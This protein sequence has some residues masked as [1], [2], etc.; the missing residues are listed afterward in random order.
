MNTLGQGNQE[1][2]YLLCCQ[3]ERFF[4]LMGCQ[5]FLETKIVKRSIHGP[6]RSA[7]VLL[8]IKPD[9]TY[10][11]TIKI[12]RQ[13]KHIP[14]VYGDKC[15]W[16][17]SDQMPK[18]K[19]RDKKRQ[20]AAS[21]SHSRDLWVEWMQLLPTYSLNKQQDQHTFLEDEAMSTAN[22]GPTNHN[23]TGSPLLFSRN[24]MLN[25]HILFSELLYL[26]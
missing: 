3:W 7:F 15:Q 12:V 2:G 1:A 11:K 17:L 10:C 18:K 26:N 8:S 22:V 23:A 19:P 24:G 16:F 14:T 4:T 6:K 13:Q 21:S 20:D 9:C 5:N 25:R